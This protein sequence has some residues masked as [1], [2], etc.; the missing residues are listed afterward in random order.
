M[1]NNWHLHGNYVRL[2]QRTLMAEAEQHRLGKP[3]Q[4]RRRILRIYGPLMY[5]VGS[6]LTLWGQRL[7]AQSG[8][9]RG[10]SREG[11]VL[12]SDCADL[13]GGC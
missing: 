3:A 7:Q 9:M 5:R 8:E 10:L 6:T 1:H 11:L 2:H 13:P 4:P 12:A